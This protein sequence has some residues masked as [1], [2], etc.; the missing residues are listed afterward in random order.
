MTHIDGA[1]FDGVGR[2][3][4]WWSA[5][6]KGGGDVYTWGV[7]G[8]Y[9]DEAYD[10]E[11]ASSYDKAYIGDTGTIGRVSSDTGKAASFLRSVRCVQD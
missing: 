9:G 3:G 5:T 8:G 6:E 11:Y 7:S 1:D 2:V 4:E 10:K